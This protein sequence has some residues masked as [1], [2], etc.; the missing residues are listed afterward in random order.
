MP[1]IMTSRKLT[2]REQKLA[3]KSAQEFVDEVNAIAHKDGVGKL[4][5]QEHWKTG[6]DA[7]RLLA[8]EEYRNTY[9]DVFGFKP[10]DT[11]Y[12]HISLDD[13]ESMTDDLFEDEDEDEDIEVDYPEDSMDG[14]HVSALASAGFGT[15]EDYGDFGGSE[16]F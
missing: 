2:R 4:V 3:A 9:K 16:D 8:I 7:A 6:L 14:D 1:D 11:N 13:I 12:E 5:C 15:D 10:S